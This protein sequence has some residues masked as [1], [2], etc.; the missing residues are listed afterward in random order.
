MI[1]WCIT[2]LGIV[3]GVTPHG[4][5]QLSLRGD[6]PMG[7]SLRVPRVRLVHGDTPEAAGTSA[8]LLGA[9]P[10]LAYET[11]RAY[12]ERE[13]SVADG[14][15]RFDQS[16]PLSEGATNSC[17]MCH[18]LPFR[19]AGTG[20]NT[21]LPGAYGRRVP[22][23]FGI[24]LIETLGLQIRQQI[25]ARYDVNNNGFLDVPEEVRGQ[26][27][28]IEASPGNTIDFG[29]LEDL[30]GDGWPELN[31]V[32]RVLPVDR[33]GREIR[34]SRTDGKTHSL[35]DKDVAG[36]DVAVD[37]IA[38]SEK[39]PSIRGFIAGVMQTFF[40]LRVHDA[41]V[42]ED[43]RSRSSRPLTDA[44]AGPTL[45]GALQLRY[46]L[47]AVD[48]KAF[49]TEGEMDVFESYILN[50]PR[51][52][53]AAQTEESRRGQQLLR[54]FLCTSCHT[55][56]WHIQAADEKRGLPGDRRFFDLAVRADSR[57]ALV[58][59]LTHLT[60]S[61]K[62][63]DGTRVDVPARGAFQVLGIYSD[64]RY[65]DLGQRFYEYRTIAGELVVERL[66]RTKP[67]WGVGSSAPYGHDGR[68]MTLD[69]VIRR[70]GG[71]GRDSAIRYAEAGRDD[72][73][74]LVAYLKSLVLYQ[75]DQLPVD[76][77]GDGVIQSDYKIDG[78]SVGPET[79]RPEL[80]WRTAPVYRGWLAGSTEDRY[81]SY[82]LMN[83]EQTHHFLF[84]VASA[85]VNRSKQVK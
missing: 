37:V 35:R 83:T 48:H 52:A 80:L 61:E 3:A 2:F 43:R 22:H 24:G 62:L 14:V 1:R 79:F 85:A 51:P 25:L 66:F 76:L 73:D 9:D 56:D 10:W 12:F 39:Q 38:V 74:A 23:L 17:A 77:D 67:L 11:G 55:E 63:A 84:G 30:N 47:P 6:D 21:A 41:S 18:N 32:I 5:A 71:E 26:R 82:E 33:H 64:L 49:V 45:A 69:D 78:K 65:H 68:S 60:R 36:Y 16:R 34:E 40:G 58:G 44:W 57:G 31:A 4:E 7:F 50:H 15:F 54:D 42:T 13:W 8:H 59:K 81:F 72:R 20:G 27:A 29:S 28:L 75:T 70:H 46:A 19:T 53:V